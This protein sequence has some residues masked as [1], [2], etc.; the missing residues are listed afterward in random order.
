ML[1]TLEPMTSSA[2][3]ARAS[4]PGRRGAKAGWPGAGSSAAGRTWVKQRRGPQS[5]PRPHAWL[6]LELA[7]FAVALVSRRLHYSVSRLAR[8][9][10]KPEVGSRRPAGADAG[11]RVA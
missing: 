6:L 3:V 4:E 2:S 5:R 7:F 10:L 11:I 9:L 1:Q 8:G